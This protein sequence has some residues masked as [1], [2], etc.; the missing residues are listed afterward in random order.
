M[1]Q[2]VVSLAAAGVLLI[3]IEMFVPGIIAGV[4]GGILLFAAVVV[5]Y[6]EGGTGAGNLVLLGAVAVTGGMWWWWATRFQKTRFG[7]SMT[8]GTSSTGLAGPQEMIASLSG[9][10]GVAVTPL[11]PSGT[12]IIAGKRVD[13]MTDGESIESGA[14]IRVIRPQGMTALVRRE[15]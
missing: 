10:I 8:L 1:I 13:A 2:T 9:Q 3:F 6:R 11:R 14:A 5:A 12:V 7:R 4:I 15:S